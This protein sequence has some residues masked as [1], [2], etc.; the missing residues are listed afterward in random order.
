MKNIFYTLIILSLFYCDKKDPEKPNTPPAAFEVTAKAEG[1]NVILTWTDSTDPDGDPITYAVVY[2]DTLAKGLTT[3]TFTIKDLPYET[4]VSGTVVASDGRGG[5]VT[6]NFKV[7]T[8]NKPNSPPKPF[9]VVAFV[10]TGSKEVVLTWSES[11]DPDGDEVKYS[12]FYK[13][14]LVSGLTTKTYTIKG[15]PYDT[16]ITGL[17]VAKDGKGGI[18]EQPFSAKTLEEIGEQ[19]YVNIPD[20]NFEAALVELKIDNI[21]DGKLLRSAAAKVKKL[22]LNSKRIGD[23]SGIEAFTD[24][25]WLN[26]S[27]N[28][29]QT[30]NLSSNNRLEELDCFSNELSSLDLGNYPKIKRMQLNSNNFKNLDLSNAKELIDLSLHN[31]RLLEKIDLDA[32]FLQ[33]LMLSY[34]N[35]KELDLSSEIN[36][37][38]L[39]TF[40]NYE[41]KRLNIR[42][43]K[44]LEDLVTQNCLLDD[45]DLSNNTELSRFEGHGNKLKTI[46]VSKNPK[47]KILF[48]NENELEELNL[49]KNNKLEYM[50]AHKNKLSVI[51]VNSLQQPTPY[52]VK[53]NTA[54][55][56][57]CN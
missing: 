18:N 45:L 51:C 28:S 25:E 30:L 29:I 11:V 14:T 36:L 23:L 40:N 41:L 38:Y 22:N 10:A 7:R 21:V 17:V 1:A 12:V 2:G 39:Y 48:I 53:D 42:N 6:Q 34:C 15:L 49:V 56:K 27:N 8:A 54:T 46:D 20:K 37:I 33:I 26:V 35:L 57:V 47:L 50:E 43:N 19:G 52:W 32:R 5:K 24:L 4:E 44:R 31:N 13:D 16:Q 55:Y 3:R 9:E